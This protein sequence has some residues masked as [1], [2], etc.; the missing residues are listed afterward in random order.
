MINRIKTAH[1]VNII[2]MAISTIICFL[3]YFFS[4]SSGFIANVYDLYGNSDIVY[5]KELMSS[6]SDDNAVI[7]IMISHRFFFILISLLNFKKRRPIFFLLPFL[8]DI[9]CLCVIS[10]TS[11]VSRT[12]SNNGIFFVWF[13][14]WIISFIGCVFSFIKL[15]REDEFI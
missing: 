9:L 4:K 15:D 8:F 3:L 6:G 14:I 1:F 5:S 12:I 13:L 11:N 10:D 7:W 2:F